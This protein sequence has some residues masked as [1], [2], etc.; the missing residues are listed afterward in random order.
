LQSW[1]DIIDAGFEPSEIKVL[2]INGGKISAIEYRLALAL[3]AAVGVVEESG[4]EVAMLLR[5]EKWVYSDKLFQLPEDV[6]TVSSFVEPKP[7]EQEPNIRVQLAKK[8]HEN[9][10][11]TKKTSIKTEDPAMNDWDNLPAELKESNAQQADDIYKKL[12]RVGLGVQKV[13]GRKANLIKLTDEEIELLAEIEHGRWNV[14][15]MN[16]GWTWGKKKDSAK[17]KSPYLVRWTDLPDDVKEWDRNAV[18]IIPELLAE[19]DLELL[20]DVR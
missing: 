10:L 2:G 12:G 11:R 9:Y 7:S 19:I 15:K 6:M 14:E 13:S 8:I 3:G 20:R 17:K 5:D 4:R 18:C 16:A 1:I